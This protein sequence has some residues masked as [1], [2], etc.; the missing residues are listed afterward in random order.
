MGA[1]S[2]RRSVPRGE[3]VSRGNCVTRGEC[4]TGWGAVARCVDTRDVPLMSRRA[5]GQ[6]GRRAGARRARWGRWGGCRGGLDL[7]CLA[8]LLLVARRLLVSARRLLL[9]A[10][11]L[12]H[13]L[14]NTRLALDPVKQLFDLCE[15]AECVLG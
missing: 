13:V 6:I 10:R 5:G 2:G 11:G 4:G 3:R 8:R 15:S 1:V 7:R 12:V 14:H 9:M